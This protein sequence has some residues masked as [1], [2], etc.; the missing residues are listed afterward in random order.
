V[1]L[2]GCL[3]DCDAA[4]AAFHDAAAAADIA[5]VEGCG[6]LFDGP[7]AACEGGVAGSE[8]ERGSTAHVAACLRAPLVLVVDAQAFSTPRAIAALV[9]GHA[10]GEGGCSVAGVILNRAPRPGLAADTQE[11]LSC[12]SLGVAV[13]GAVPTLADL[14]QLRAGGSGAAG[15]WPAAAATCSISLQGWMSCSKQQQLLA[16]HVAQH[17][18]LQRLR[19]L[20]RSAAVPQ[21]QA[22]LPP[23]AR[24]YRVSMA[25]AHDA[26][27]YRYFQQ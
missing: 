25:V 12:A 16:Q 7:A 6:G 27:F 2:D 3:L 1:G 17:V 11:A 22:P 23:P 10:A 24:T 5:L 14:E 8:C 4:R 13:L 15:V 21:P 26:A 18:D 19:Q 20:A 9:R